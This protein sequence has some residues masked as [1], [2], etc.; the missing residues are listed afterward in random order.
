MK[1]NRR[2]AL[3]VGAVVFAVAALAGCG[4]EGKIGNYG[5]VS[6]WPSADPRGQA[7]V[8][9]LTTLMTVTVECH[10]PGKVDAKGFGY[11]GS[12]KVS[13]DGGSGYIDDSTEIMSDD[14]VVSPDRVSEC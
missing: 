5:N 9:K 1:L 2:V 14:G 11:G 7:P 12:Y 8:G 4:V 10:V 13:Y 3:P 6:V